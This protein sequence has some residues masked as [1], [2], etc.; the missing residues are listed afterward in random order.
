MQRQVTV[1]AAVQS[2]NPANAG[3][4]SGN[5]DAARAALNAIGEVQSVTSV[6]TNYMQYSAALQSAKI[7]FDAAMR[8]YKPRDEADEKISRDLEA[9][10]DAYVAARDVWSAFIESGERYC[11]SAEKVRT[12][13]AR[14]NLAISDGDICEEVALQSLWAKASKNL[15][16][17]NTRL[18]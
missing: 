17:V 16:D 4:S 2:G 7:K 12:I 8:D 14:Y 6:G 5:H 18:R 3:V 9:A 1:Q 15:N 10:F 13:V 11:M